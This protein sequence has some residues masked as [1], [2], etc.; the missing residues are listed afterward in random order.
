[1]KKTLPQTIYVRLQQD[2][3]DQWLQAEINLRDHLDIDETRLIGEYKLVARH[4]VTAEI[5]AVKK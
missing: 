4:E 1:M 2:R 3:D 5:K